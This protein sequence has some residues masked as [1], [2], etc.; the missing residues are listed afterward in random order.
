MD[1][2]TER[3]G[4]TYKEE[5][6]YSNLIKWFDYC[7][8]RSLVRTQQVIA[9]ALFSPIPPSSS[10]S[11]SPSSPPPVVHANIHRNNLVRKVV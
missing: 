7:F 1:D 11:S 5:R 4:K 9:E 2:K 8:R 6:S 10:P 3:F